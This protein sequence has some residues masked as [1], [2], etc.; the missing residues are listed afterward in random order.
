MTAAPWPRARRPGPGYLLPGCIALLGG[1]AMAAGDTAMV[2]A[3]F[4]IARRH[5]GTVR[6][7]VVGG[8][9]TGAL[10]KPRISDAAFTRALAASV[11][12]SGVF[13]EVAHGTRGDWV[14][15]VILVRLD[16]PVV[17]ITATVRLEAGWALKRS[18]AGST[19]WKA[20]IESRA[21]ETGLGAATEGAARNN[22]AEGLARI[23]RL[24]L[25][26]QK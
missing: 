20:V 21:T 15:S 18:D 1:C 23:S 19:V 24:D 12:R 4:D 7:E 3:S 25:S 17:A 16:Q 10:D 9:D 26:M 2:P 11:L 13:P 14:L 5:P 6:V 22:I 8:S